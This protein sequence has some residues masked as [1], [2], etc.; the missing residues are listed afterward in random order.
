MLSPFRWG[1]ENNFL[2]MICKTSAHP[3]ME[4]SH[5][6]R[7][8]LSNCFTRQLTTLRSVI[9]GGDDEKIVGCSLKTIRVF[10]REKYDTQKFSNSPA[11][12]PFITLSPLMLR[13]DFSQ[14]S[15]IIFHAFI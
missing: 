8:F 2:T 1:M 9:E 5:M 13:S 12:T 15:A 11:V 10:I 4:K 6:M 14:R 3:V 7:K